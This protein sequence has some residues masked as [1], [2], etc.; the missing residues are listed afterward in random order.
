MILPKQKI[1]LT[2][3]DNNILHEQ[4]AKPIAKPPTK[5]IQCPLSLPASLHI[6]PD[7]LL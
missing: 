4:I 1:E 3:K 5:P 2:I 6:Q 7:P